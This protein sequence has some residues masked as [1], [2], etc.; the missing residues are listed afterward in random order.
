VAGDAA[1]IAGASRFHSRT[2]EF[3]MRTYDRC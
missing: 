1:G 2:P 3:V